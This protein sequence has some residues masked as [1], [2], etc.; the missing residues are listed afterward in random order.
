MN[1]PTHRSVRKPATQLRW[2]GVAGPR[3]ARVAATMLMLAVVVAGRAGAEELRPWRDYQAI[4][5]VGNSA[6]KQPDK[7]PLFFDRLREMGIT[8]VSV[9]ADR[10]VPAALPDNLGFYVENVVNRG[11]CLKF[12]SS[13]REWDKFITTWSKEGRPA[14]ALVRDY[15]LDDPSWRGWA[16]DQVRAAVRR[17]SA[18]A[19]L[20]YDLRDELSTT[21][22][23]NPF[24]YDFGPRALAGFRTWLKTQYDGLARLNEQWGTKFADWNDVKPFTTDQIKARM[25][26]SVSPVPET[27]P[28]WR[29]LQRLQ[30]D[31][32]R[33]RA[34]PAR[35]NFAPWADFRT[36]MDI[37][38]AS[39]LGDL[40]QAARELDPSTPVGIEGTQMPSA[41][42]GYDLWRL[43]RVLDW[44]EPYDIGNARE[45]LGSF[46][47][48]KPMLTTVFEK[49]TRLA[50]RRLWH[51][52]LVGDR[53]CIIWWSEDCID[54]QS[55]EYALTAK[56]RALAPVLRELQSPLA[57]LFLSAERELDPIYL[58]YSQP[59]IQV[60]WL[61]ESTRDGAS[62]PRRFSSFE[63]RHNR[64]AEKRAAWVKL[65]QDLGYTPQFVPAEQLPALANRRPGGAT[66]VLSDALAL[67]AV[68]ARAAREFIER[69]D[70]VRGN[71]LI[72]DAPAGVFDEHGRLRPGAGI[73]DAHSRDRAITISRAGAERHFERDIATFG[74]ARLT[75]RVDD[76]FEW[77]E[78]QLG[79]PRSVIV[80]A[81]THTRIHRY[82]AGDARLIAFERNIAYHMSEDLKQAGG[83]EP[84]EQPVS[85]TAR[86]VDPAHVYDLRAQRYLGRTDRIAF[87]LDP[88]QPSLF[89]L[90]PEALPAGE[91]IVAA[92]L[93]KRHE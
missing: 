21:I 45:I 28:D 64:L 86:F 54:W 16:R 71:V 17:H 32:D 56:A 1:R 79:L 15:C 18:R 44:V 62:W 14:A 83:N 31:R 88:W 27:A 87:T 48:G 76:W 70:R 49:E 40:R 82:R 24:D 34:E 59:S 37:S 20:A 69:G 55:G 30:F 23:A 41:F 65:F 39:T 85:I 77:A 38:L 74:R 80:P 90:L 52:L 29:A 42:G 81:A 7:L 84:L 47:P 10:P 66:W 3:S 67:S 57:R 35:W 6:L 75:G 22:S 13:V 43:A 4:M 5:W 63:A 46:M 78:Q 53:G 91:D 68:E 8:A 89:A 50:G 61:L 92:L 33:A 51:L 36:Y 60:D 58:V 72:A 26:G 25:A 93:R 73:L 12:N 19:P 9:H 2:P 11:L